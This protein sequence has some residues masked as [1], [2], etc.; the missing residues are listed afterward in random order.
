MISKPAVAAYAI[1]ILMKYSLRHTLFLPVVLAVIFSSCATYNQKIQTYYDYM[2]RGNYKK[3]SDALD[4]NKYLQKS[5]NQFLYL[6]EKGRV[7]YLMERYSESNFFFNKAD[8]M[9]E[10]EKKTT[11]DAVKGTLLNPMMQTYAVQD[12]ERFMLHYYKAINYCNL[13]NMEDAIV[14]A[15]RIT[16]D[17]NLLSDIKKDK[18]NKYSKDA[19][20]LVV[21]GMLYEKNG[22][23]NNAFISYRNAVE[24]Y[25]SQAD[26]TWYGITVPE[27]LKKDVIR[28]AALM[29]FKDEQ[30]RFEN[31]F[32]QKYVRDTASGGSMIIFWEHGKAPI[33]SE[34]NII[35]TLIKNEAGMLTYQSELGSFNI[36]I[37][38]GLNSNSGTN[39]LGSFQTFRIALPQYLPLSSNN[40]SASL[41]I[42]DGV[43][44]NLEPVMDVNAVAIAVL[45]ERRAKDITNALI[46][47][48]AKKAIEV[49]AKAA[50][51]A[52]AENNSK[53]EDDQKKKQEAE[54]ISNVVG[55]AVQAFSFFSEKADTRNWQTLPSGIQYIRVPLQRGA[56]KIIVTP[57]GGTTRKII[58]VNGNGSIQ[59]Y[60]F[61]TN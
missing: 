43:S 24:T 13:N 4:N 5:R 7:S 58:D 57:Q 6:V 17:N 14:E 1:H 20:S 60:S 54:N 44:A 10:D 9:A 32:G 56:N 49:G 15:R 18:T 55:A 40:V 37:P 53:K 59:L 34:Q 27:Q 51:K 11:G 16:L 2:Q 33:K 47:L 45:K 39:D 26:H 29:G 31:M 52:I 23:I 38:V 36:P 8:N 19:F 61:Y 12:F 42:N 30:N 3:A 21:Q 28:T 50:T 46:R 48:A 35:L 25:T 41:T 22:D